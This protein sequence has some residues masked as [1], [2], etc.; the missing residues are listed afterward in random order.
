MKRWPALLLILLL[1]PGC[2]KSMEKQIQDQV[3]T[4]G[5][6]SLDREQVQIT[7]IQEMGDYAIAEVQV[8]TAVKLRK[9]RD[10]WILDEVRLGDRR[11]ERAE[12]ILKALNQERAEATLRQLQSIQQ[13]IQ[14]YESQNGSVPQVASFEALI[15]VLTPKYESQVIRIDAWS[16]SFYYRAAGTHRYSLRSGGGDGR[17]G[18][19]DDLRLDRP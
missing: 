19:E 13:G 18:T 17:V 10:Q 16:N 11:W 5:G 4:L 14:K 2:G 15:D 7:G 3:R 6:A 1:V 9:E 8:S 12:N